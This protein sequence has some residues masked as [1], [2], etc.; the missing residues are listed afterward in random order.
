M[1]WDVPACT[2][3]PGYR[4]RRKQLLRHEGHGL[5]RRCSDTPP[6]L[7]WMNNF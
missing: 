7:N 1:A 5:Y 3:L 6:L 4:A 2:C